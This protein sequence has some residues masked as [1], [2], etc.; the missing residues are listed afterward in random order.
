MRKKRSR[1]RSALGSGSN[2]PNERGKKKGK[3]RKRRTQKGGGGRNTL[4]NLLPAATDLL[5][6]GKKRERKGEM[7]LRN[8]LDP[9]PLSRP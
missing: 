1:L 9:L 2:G 6:E 8:W 3:E 4:T 5:G 7:L